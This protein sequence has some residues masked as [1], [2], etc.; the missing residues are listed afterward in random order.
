MKR[1][2]LRLPVVLLLLVELI[3]LIPLNTM[4]SRA[5]PTDESRKDKI[6]FDGQAHEVGSVVLPHE[7]EGQQVPEPDEPTPAES[8]PGPDL[9]DDPAV[10][11]GPEEGT[12]GEET[13]GDTEPEDPGPPAEEGSD[14]VEEPPEPT[15]V[16]SGNI[17]ESERVDASYFD[18]VVFI[19][20]SVSLKLQYFVRDMRKKDENYL[21]GAQFLTAG[22]FSYINAL[23]P[24]S[25]DSTHPTY[26]GSKMLLEDSIAA[27]GARKL[28]I[29]LGMNDIAGGR[30]EDTLKDVGLVAARILEKNPDAVFY[31]QSVTPRMADSQTRKLNNEIIRTYNEYLL[32]YCEENGYFFVD[33]YSVL[34]DEN[35]DLPAEYC[36]DPVSLGGM[37]IHFTDR[38]CE[39]WI[40]YLYT[41]TA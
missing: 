37:G 13:P 18:D 20:D 2:F 31:F 35:G 33:V 39:A 36:S 26:Q 23:K 3:V 15:E 30:Y 7:Q 8:D 25:S 29:M 19:G 14:G 22:S 16:V 21:G 9:V 17:P 1:F 38:A 32:H 4:S 34:S 27:C 12:N 24:V 28:Y 11:P 10:G 6:T 41:H 5:V 40:E